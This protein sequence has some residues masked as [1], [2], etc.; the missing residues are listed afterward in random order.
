MGRQFL[1]VTAAALFVA[2]S[3]TGTVLGQG[4]P[5]PHFRSRAPGGG[6]GGNGGFKPGP[7]RDRFYQ[8]SPDERQ[9]LRRN[10]ERWLQMNPEQQKI[11]RE[12]AKAR[13]QMLRAEA[14]EAIRQMGLRLDPNAQG[15]FEARYLQERRRIERQLHQEVESRR[16]QQLPQLNERLKSEFEPRQSSGPNGTAVPAASPS[17]SSKP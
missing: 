4:Q 7:G 9:A 17:V 8:L 1:I 14:E 15:Q 5:T 13:R 6:R 3:S 10:A 2:L 12:R 16:Q 11:L